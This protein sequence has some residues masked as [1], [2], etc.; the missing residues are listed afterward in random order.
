MNKPSPT[1]K[2]SSD[3]TFGVNEEVFLANIANKER[4]IFLVIRYQHTVMG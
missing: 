3:M 4:F 1:I 2:F